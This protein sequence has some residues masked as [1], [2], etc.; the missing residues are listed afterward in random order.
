MRNR[1][2]NNVDANKIVIGCHTIKRTKQV[3]SLFLC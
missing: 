2:K 1:L 3:E